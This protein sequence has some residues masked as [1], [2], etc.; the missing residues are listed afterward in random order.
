[1]WSS[2]GAQP[3]V[4]VWGGGQ[5]KGADF[6]EGIRAVLID[7]DQAPKWSPAALAAV[8]DEYLLKTYF[9]PVRCACWRGSVCIYTCVGLWD[10]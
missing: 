5:T 2:S 3:T 8:S 1:V 6:Y 10:P 4:P 7:K 9:A